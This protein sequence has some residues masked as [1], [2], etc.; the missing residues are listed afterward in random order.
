L[1]TV[2][3]AWIPD[4][5]DSTREAR[6]LQEMPDEKRET[7]RRMRFAKGRAAS[8]LGLQLLKFGIRALGYDNFALSTVSFPRGDKPRCTLP[9][10]FNISHSG[11]LVACAIAAVGR[12]GIDVERRREVRSEA[13]QKF[14]HPHERIWVGADQR[15]FFELWTQ[16]EAIVKGFGRG[17]IV[18]LR[19][20]VIDEREGIIEDQLWSLRELN[21]H[22]DYVAHVA[23]DEDAAHAPIDI[24]RVFVD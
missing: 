2:A 21:I 17:G 24:Q 9:I 23:V 6:W 7:I 5:L 22:P 19:N 18:N 12:V 13:F 3:Y 14:L 11:D 8:L 16:K 1:V 15:R 4:N 20:T 10:D